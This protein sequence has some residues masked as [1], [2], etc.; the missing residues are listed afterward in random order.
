MRNTLIGLVVMVVSLGCGDDDVPMDLGT[1]TLPDVT[2]DAENDAAED[3]ATDANIADAVSD[4]V[5]D[6]ADDLTQDLA[7]D[8]VEDAMVDGM[9]D[10]MVDADVDAAADASGECHDVMFAGPEVSLQMVSQLPVL[11]GGTIMPGTYVATEFLTT[12]GLSGALRATWV[13]DATS[14]NQIQQLTLG[15]AGPLTPRTYTWQAAGDQLTR[16]EECPGNDVISTSFTATA[17]SLTV[18]ISNAVH[19]VLQRQ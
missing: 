13:I 8:V 15:A 10:A 17:T 12:G 3:V 11:T 4:T 1:D 16:T 6:V 5:E 19:I 14:I 2:A 18:G 9:V 7:V